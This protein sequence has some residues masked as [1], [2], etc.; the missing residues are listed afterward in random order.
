MCGIAGII[1]RDG[2]VD[3]DTLDR[4]TASM[5]HRGPDDGG[6]FVDRRDGFAVGLGNRRLSIIDLS[7]AGHQPMCNETADVWLV[8][9]GELYNNAELR[10]TLENRGHI[11]RSRI[12]T[13]TII[14]TYEEFGLECFKK[15]NGMFALALYDIRRRRVVLARDRMG[16]KP[17]YYRS[18]GRTFVFASELKTL[19]IHPHVP[20]EVNL[21]ALDLYLSL[22]YVPS[23]FCILRD[24]HKLLPGHYTLIDEG[25]SRTQEFWKPI[26]EPNPTNKLS[27]IHFA[28]QTKAIV[29]DAVRRQIV[30][31]VPV[32]VLLSGGI[33]STIIG[34][35][36]QRHTTQ[37]LRSFS[38]GYADASLKTQEVQELINEDLNYARLVSKWL[39]TD[40]HEVV[41]H[42]EQL[43]D[44]LPRLIA[45]LDEPFCEATS[46]AIYAVAC[47]ARQHGVKVVLTGDGSDELF[48][49]YAWYE[50][51]RRLDR[52][53]Q[54]PGLRFGLSVLSHFPL[55]RR[56]RLKV[57]DLCLKAGQPPT[58]KYRLIY[59]LMTTAERHVLIAPDLA[60]QLQD[61]LWEQVVT[62]FIDGHT[63]LPYRLAYADLNLW[64]RELFNP[65]ID[66]M[67]MMCSVEARVPFQDNQV[68]DFALKLPI[69]MKIRRGQNK[70]LLRRAFQSILPP[71]VL[72]RPK[73]S[74]VGPMSIWLRGGLRELALDLLAPSQLA[75]FGLLAP[76][77]VT[78]LVR[79]V[80]QG[81]SDENVPIVWM[82]LTLQLWCE[83][84]LN[85]TQ[86]T[87]PSEVACA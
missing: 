48:G 19:L 55:G 59:H 84:Y 58:Q 86:P 64:V 24:V 3:E 54:L 16:I 12:D 36:T 23:P 78:P 6:V 53:E 11:Y 71:A 73:R 38:V 32:G 80:I 57:Q 74:F 47:L 75:R 10:S 40:H 31:D 60:N 25:G 56:T 20:R 8:Y 42:G 39:G 52:Y 44:L 1:S 4:M 49:G 41:L 30:S 26:R 33:D 70:Y 18:D 46:P 51:A 5:K 68:L 9:N 66:R 43:P 21:Q 61:N 87:S 29:E 67:T 77:T 63:P 7:A 35:I 37:R 15:L 50:S 62:P 28:T 45:Q 27:E 83:A 34:S 85:Q 22:Y 76:K 82:L 69:N 81:Q 14:H 17:L 65:R 79:Q 13:E 72:T 2:E